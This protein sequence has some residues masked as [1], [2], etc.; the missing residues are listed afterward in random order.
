MPQR[1]F[2]IDEQKQQF[3]TASWRYNWSNFKLRYQEEVVCSM[4]TKKDLAT[5]RQFVMPDG[6]LLSV[7]LKGNVKPEL[8]LLRDGLPLQSN[9]TNSR[10]SQR[11]AMQLA[12]FM[13]I[14]NMIAGITAA[15]TQSDIM[16]SIGFGYGSI[17]VGVV[18][19]LLAVGVR[20]L[21]SY[22]V[23]AVAT[24]VFSD[25][26]LLFVFTDMKEGPT[27]PTSGFLIKLFLVYAFIK[28]VRAMKQIKAQATATT[29]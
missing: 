4:A 17:A 13:G 2:Y 12:L 14:L 3:L 1:L 23:F 28:G 26:V 10:S 27:S 8:E 22:A 5:G 11:T 19:L 25:I 21:S 20:R 24:W 18:Y 6:H 7:R 29:T 15:V 16:L 9:T